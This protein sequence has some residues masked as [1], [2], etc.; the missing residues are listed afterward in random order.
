MIEMF[1]SYMLPPLYKLLKN[2]AAKFPLQ[3]QYHLR[4]CAEKKEKT[5]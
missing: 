1:D 4:F 2:D 3:H 5:V